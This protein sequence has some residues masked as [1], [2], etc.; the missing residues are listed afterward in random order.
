MELAEFLEKI[1]LNSEA[2]KE[3]LALPLSEQ[4]YEDFKEAFLYTRQ[5]FFERIV[6][7]KNYR[8]KLLYL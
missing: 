7:E 4:E 5:T 2:K 8:I 6:Q 1:S 3:L